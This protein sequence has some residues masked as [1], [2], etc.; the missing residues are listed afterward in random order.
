VNDLARSLASDLPDRSSVSL[1]PT[2]HPV[3]KRKQDHSHKDD[4][5][6]IHVLGSD[7]Q[8]NWEWQEYNQENAKGNRENVDG[9]P[10]LAQVPRSE[11]DWTVIAESTDCKHQDWNTVREV[12]ADC[13]E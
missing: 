2:N 3:N 13:C 7:W 4:R 1:P 10:N 9:Q 6:I 5:S 8:N 11:L 12:E